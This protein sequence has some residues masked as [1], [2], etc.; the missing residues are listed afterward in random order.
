MASTSWDKGQVG[1]GMLL[2]VALFVTVASVSLEQVLWVPLLVVCFLTV[3]G[4]VLF[5]KYDPKSL[6]LGFWLL[7]LPLSLFL[8]YDIEA[9]LYGLLGFFITWIVVVGAASIIVF[10]KK[11][12]FDKQALEEAAR[13]EARAAEARAAVEVEEKVAK[14]REVVHKF[15]RGTVAE[16][17]A[18]DDGAS[19]LK[20]FCPFCNGEVQLSDKTCPNCGSEIPEKEHA[21]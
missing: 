15:A 12:A 10:L 4:G 18:R 5:K 1:F 3:V 21:I 13:E 20:Y 14:A 2:V 6:S 19:S 16:L 11:P 8:L 9:F 17:V 7:G